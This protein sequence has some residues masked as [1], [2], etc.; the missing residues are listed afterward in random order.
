MAH[1]NFK[2]MLHATG[3]GKTTEEL[4]PEIVCNIDDEDC[5]CSRCPAC[6]GKGALLSI[7]ESA[8]DMDKVEDFH[9]EHW[10]AGVRCR[11]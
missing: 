7:L 1:Q 4:T 3:F 8:L 5:V 10:I 11:Q 6:P 9:V 2:L